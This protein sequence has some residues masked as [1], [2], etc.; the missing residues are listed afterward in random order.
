M[1]L[2]LPDPHPDPLVTSNNPYPDQALDPSIRICMFLGL[3]DPH[4][5]LVR[6]TDPR[7]RIRTKMLRIRSTGFTHPDPTSPNR[8]WLNKTG[9][10]G[11][12]GGGPNTFF[13][14]FF[15]LVYN[16]DNG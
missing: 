12:W 6:G 2:G 7:I 1:F 3:P 11:G 5:D 13:C 16:L 4:L 10:V 15:P 9:L 14:G 8:I